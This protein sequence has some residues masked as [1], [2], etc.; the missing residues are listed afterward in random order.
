MN[1][2]A[3]EKEYPL[4]TPQDLVLMC[5]KHALMPI[6]IT[7]ENCEEFICS[8]CAKEDHKNHDWITISTAA[9]LKTRGLLKAMAKIEEEDTLQIDEQI[10]EASKQMEENKKRCET[11]IARMQTHYDAILEKLKK[12]KQRHEKTLRHSLE[13][14]NDDMSKVRSSLE[15]KKKKVL[16]RVKSLTENI[17]TMTDNCLL[18]T[19][20]LP[21]ICSV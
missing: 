12:I 8:K 4:G 18:Y 15:E 3:M 14:K 21:T 9:T 17:S 2:S 5:E 20:E 16:Q 7:C 1:V 19:S 6:D 13:I 10:Q 11:E